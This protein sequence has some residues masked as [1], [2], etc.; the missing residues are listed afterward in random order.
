MH[1][2][3]NWFFILKNQIRTVRGYLEAM[4]KANPNIAKYDPLL[5]PRLNITFPKFV[6]HNPQSTVK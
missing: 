6:L 5:P 3:P 2:L 1:A 4:F